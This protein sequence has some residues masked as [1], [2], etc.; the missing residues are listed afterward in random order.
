M[1]VC[2]KGWPGLKWLEAK[3]NCSSP[4]FA[5]F[6]GHGNLRPTVFSFHSSNAT[7]AGNEAI[8]TRPRKTA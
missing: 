1:G 6:S 5:S 7:P 4:Y 3:I 2:G 8:L